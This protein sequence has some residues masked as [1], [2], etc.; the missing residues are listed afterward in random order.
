MYIVYRVC[1]KLLQTKI[2]TARKESKSKVLVENLKRIL[3]GNWLERITHCWCAC[4][5]VQMEN[6]LEKTRKSEILIIKIF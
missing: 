4:L 5:Q 3:I 2:A 1:K 6:L